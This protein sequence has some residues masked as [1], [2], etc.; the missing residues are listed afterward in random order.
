MK[1][2]LGQS[3]SV[4]FFIFI[5]WPNY[6]NEMERL[7]DGLKRVFFYLLPTKFVFKIPQ[8]WKHWPIV[9]SNEAETVETVGGDN[10]PIACNSQVRRRERR[11]RSISDSEETLRV[12]FWLAAGKLAWPVGGCESANFVPDSSHFVRIYLCHHGP[13]RLVSSETLR[14][15]R[16]QRHGPPTKSRLVG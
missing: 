3:K 9:R 13:N 8:S 10:A 15:R 1:I 12:L 6:T 16:V 7:G 5:L 11:R 2:V 4:D 14:L